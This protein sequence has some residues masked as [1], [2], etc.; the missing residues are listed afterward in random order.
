MQRDRTDQT[1]LT[2]VVSFVKDASCGG[3]FISLKIHGSCILNLCIF[4]QQNANRTFANEINVF[5]DITTGID[6]RVAKEDLED[7]R[8][9]QDRTGEQ[10]CEA[11]EREREEGEDGT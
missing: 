7:K 2:K 10:R 4:T 5:T 6:Q 1:H 11:E 3:Y 8:T 9:R